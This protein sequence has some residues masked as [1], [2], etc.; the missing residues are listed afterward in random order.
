MTLETEPETAQE[1]E[2]EASEATLYFF[3]HLFV[4]A[5]KSYFAKRQFYT[6]DN[7]GKP[8]NTNQNKL[9]FSCINF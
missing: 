5:L 2:L 7:V 9:P 4:L 6:S 1:E 8:Q 3:N